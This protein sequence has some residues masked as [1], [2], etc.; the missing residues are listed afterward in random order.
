MGQPHHHRPQRRH[1]HPRREPR[2]RIRPAIRPNRNKWAFIMPTS[3]T[4]NPTYIRAVSTSSPATGT[5]THLVGT[6]SAATQHALALRQ[7]HARRNHHRRH[8]DQRHRYAHSWPRT[9]ERC[10]DRLL[11]RR[12]QQHSGLELRPTATPVTALYQQVKLS[13]QRGGGEV[14]PRPSSADIRAL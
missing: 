6:Y 5:W 1:H 8:P 9:G 10:S 7:R 2:L 4:A 13:L 11:H 3:D 12:P 14:R